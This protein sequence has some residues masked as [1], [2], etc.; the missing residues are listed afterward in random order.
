MK[1][2]DYYYNNRDLRLLLDLL[3]SASGVATSLRILALFDDVFGEQI[4][5]P[6]DLKLTSPNSRNSKPEVGTE[7]KFTDAIAIDELFHI[8]DLNFLYTVEVIPPPA[9][10]SIMCIKVG[11]VNLRSQF[12]LYFTYQDMI[13]YFEYILL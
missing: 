4:F 7:L 9:E 5:Q 2:N 3:A 12:L 1:L 13:L 6:G 10:F 8:D 11:L